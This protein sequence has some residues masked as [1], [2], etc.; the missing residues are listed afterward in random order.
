[1]QSIIDKLKESGYVIYA[2]SDTT[3]LFAADREENTPILQVQK[4][5]GGSIT[6]GYVEPD[7]TAAKAAHAVLQYASVDD[8]PEAAVLKADIENI[9][10]D[11]VAHM[12]NIVAELGIEQLTENKEIN[13]LADAMKEALNRVGVKILMVGQFKIPCVIKSDTENGNVS[14]DSV[15]GFNYTMGEK[16]CGIILFATDTNPKTNVRAL[17]FYLPTEDGKRSPIIASGLV[18][19]DSEKRSAVSDKNGYSIRWQWGFMKLQDMLD[20]LDD[21]PKSLRNTFASCVPTSGK[22]KSVISKM[23]MVFMNMF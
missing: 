20:R 18:Y 6:I 16:Y 8:V 21:F 1:M 4:G 2:T 23:P 15:M 5:K 11:D 10:A 19:I 9:T 7:S 22:E 3:I 12:R 17:R 14:L 13:D